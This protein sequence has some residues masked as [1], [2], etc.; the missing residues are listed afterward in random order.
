MQIDL[1]CDLGEGMTTDEQIIP[2][3]SSANIACGFHAGD[4]D[5]MK[6]TIAHCLQYGVAIGAH[7]SWPDK[8]NFGRKEM[9]RST[10]ELITIITEQLN[11]LSQLTKD[12]KSVV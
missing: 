11:I 6:R 8:E 7:P 10:E 1:N 4:V 5:T 3:I 9:K 2:L 12:R